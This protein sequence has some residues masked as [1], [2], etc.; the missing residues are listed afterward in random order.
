MAHDCTDRHG[1]S[2]TMNAV[3]ES[4]CVSVQHFAAIDRLHTLPTMTRIAGW[5]GWGG[6]GMEGETPSVVT[7]H[8]WNPG[9]PCPFLA[10]QSSFN[11]ACFQFQSNSSTSSP[12]TKSPRTTCVSGWQDGERIGP[13]VKVLA[14]EALVVEV[15]SAEV[16]EQSGRHA[17][18]LHGV[19][20]LLAPRA[21][22]RCRMCF[23]FHDDSLKANEIRDVVVLK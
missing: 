4:P 15:V 19:E 8:P 21:C 6:T 5:H 3:R 20:Y 22:Q 10:N 7:S 18:T 9:N 2:R 14:E 12:S 1:L 13:G 11:G 17:R 16:D 23:D